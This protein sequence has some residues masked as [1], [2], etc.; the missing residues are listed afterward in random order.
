MNRFK[1][2]GQPSGHGL[3]QGQLFGFEPRRPQQHRSEVRQSGSLPAQIQQGI[4]RREA[5]RTA[6]R[7]HAEMQE[8]FEAVLPRIAELVGEGF[9]RKAFREEMAEYLLKSGVPMEALR[10]MSRGYE[11]EICTKAMLFDKMQKRRAEAEAKLA[12]VPAVLSPRRS[13][14]EEGDRLGRA[15]AALNKNPNSTEALAALFAAM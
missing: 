14:R 9:E 15:R 12:D 10:A 11:L 4:A 3:P 5:E 2:D 13:G 6:Q 8:S 7:I 1:M